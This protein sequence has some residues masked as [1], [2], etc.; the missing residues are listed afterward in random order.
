M[1]RA[2][3]RQFRGLTASSVLDASAVLGALPDAAL[4]IGAEN[5]ILYVNPSAETF[6]DAGALVLYATKI[7]DLLPPDSPLLAVLGQVRRSGLSGGT[8]SSILVAYKTNA[9]ASKNVSAD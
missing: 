9:P 3:V 2:S 5:E 8:R 6:F 1:S 4:V 7:D